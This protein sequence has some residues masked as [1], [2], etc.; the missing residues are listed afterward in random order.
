M[1]GHF[2]DRL[3]AAVRQR[4]NP[5]LVGLDPRR[6]QLPKSLLRSTAETSPDEIA[7]AYRT[8][9][10]AVVD[11][12][13]GL[14]AA[15]KPQ[16]AF[17]EELGPAGMTALFDVVKHAHAAGLLVILD[18]KRGDIGSTAAAY[19][20][21]L[22]GPGEASPWGGDALTVNPYLG[23]D[24]LEPLV[25]TAA[26]RGAGLFV[27]VKT[28]NSGG[29]QFQDLVA[30]G[31]PVYRHVAE[32]VERMAADSQGSCGYGHVGAVVGATYPEQL[33]ELREVLQHSWLLVPGY[34]SQGGRAQDV[35]AAFDQQGLGAIIN[36]SRAIIYAHRR[37]PYAARY[38]E[39]RWAE[40]VAA[41]TRDMVDEL[42]AETN[43][44]RL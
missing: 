10:C 29:G 13:A 27:L 36:S 11:A 24:S 37:E 30:D 32:L 38:G 6:H 31:R 19:A 44:G 25:N 40:A 12:V 28:S 35:R 41:A 14:V 5:V 23:D 15:V 17:F 26:E 22:L 3:A 18:G 9:C 42:R 8:F 7:S 39:A 21:G 34:G 16:M 20:A 33:N 1:A 2:A 43:A 4:G